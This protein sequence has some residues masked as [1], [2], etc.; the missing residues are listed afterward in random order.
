MVGKSEDSPDQGNKGGWK[1]NTHW[2]GVRP[3]AGLQ[4]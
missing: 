1:P 3:V 4:R 2:K